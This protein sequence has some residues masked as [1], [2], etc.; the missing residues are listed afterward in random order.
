M[1]FAMHKEGL[2]YR[3]IANAVGLTDNTVRTTILNPKKRYITRTEDAKRRARVLT[4]RGT[5]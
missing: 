2:S 3:R 1:I 5:A 4:G